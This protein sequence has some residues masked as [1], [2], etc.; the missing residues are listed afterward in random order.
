M[1]DHVDFG[2][3]SRIFAALPTAVQFLYWSAGAYIAAFWMLEG[4]VLLVAP[5]LAFLYSVIFPFLPG[6][7]FAV[8]GISLGV[9]AT[10]LAVAHYAFHG[11]N[12]K[13]VLFW[14][15]FSFA[16][17]IFIGL[18][19]TGNSPVSNYDKV[20]KETAQ[21]L[22]VVVLLYLLLIPVMFLL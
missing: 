14:I 3:Q 7:Q 18:S 12:L 9:I 11:F 13:L 8:K 10:V 1:S 16:T 21:F 2:L 15:V 4:A 20:R 17:S 19:F 5:G 22:P 6:R